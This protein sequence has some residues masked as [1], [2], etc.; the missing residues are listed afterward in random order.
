MPGPSSADCKTSLTVLKLSSFVSPMTSS[1]SVAG[2]LRGGKRC[3][4]LVGEGSDQ[5]AGL[6]SMLSESVGGRGLAGDLADANECL[7]RGVGDR[8][9]VLNPVDGELGG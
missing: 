1:L 5:D 6:L 7:N 4:G 3:C 9:E 8:V 2:A